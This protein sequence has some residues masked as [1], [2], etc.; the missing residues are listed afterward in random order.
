MVVPEMPRFSRFSRSGVFPNAKSYWHKP[1]EAGGR[2]DQEPEEPREVNPT[3]QI[4][5]C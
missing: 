3:A 2:E 4:I 1:N 5:Q